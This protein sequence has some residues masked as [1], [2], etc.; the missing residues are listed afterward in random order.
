MDHYL[1]LISISWVGW[2]VG[3]LLKALSVQI[4]CIVT[5]SVKLVWVV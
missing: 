3:Q 5:L 4:G 1:D 2:S